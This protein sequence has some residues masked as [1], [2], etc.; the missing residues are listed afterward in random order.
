M[1]TEQCIWNIVFNHDHDLGGVFDYFIF[2]IFSSE[3]SCVSQDTLFKVSLSC[4]GQYEAEGNIVTAAE[5]ITGE[6]RTA[7]GDFHCYL[8]FRPGIPRQAH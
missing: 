5:T 8:T 7:L 1:D 3:F 4:R 6:V 2:Y